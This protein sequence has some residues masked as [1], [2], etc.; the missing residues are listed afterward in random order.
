MN[1]IKTEPPKQEY[2]I[3]VND[4]TASTPILIDFEN[5]NPVQKCLLSFRGCEGVAC[6][7]ETGD[8]A[9]KTV[10]SGKRV[11]KNFSLDDGQVYNLDIS[12]VKN[13]YISG[14]AVESGASGYLVLQLT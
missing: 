8:N 4:A 13:K 2:Y 11:A 7:S 5:T 9:D 1:P 12:R 6:L 3:A 14:I 10:T